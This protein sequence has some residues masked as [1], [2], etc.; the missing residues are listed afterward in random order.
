M[1]EEMAALTLLGESADWLKDAEGRS[2]RDH[3]MAA[4]ESFQAAWSGPTDNARQTAAHEAF[5]RLLVAL[6]HNHLYPSAL[7]LDVAGDKGARYLPALGTARRDFEHLQNFCVVNKFGIGEAHLLYLSL[8]LC[9]MLHRPDKTPYDNVL[10]NAVGDVIFLRVPLYRADNLGAFSS[11]L[12][13]RF[14]A[15]RIMRSMR[16]M[17]LMDES[18]VTDLTPQD[19]H[20]MRQML[21][22]PL[23][24]TAGHYAQRPYRLAFAVVDA[25]TALEEHARAHAASRASVDDRPPEE[26][27]TRLRHRI[28][29]LRER[30]DI[31]PNC[32]ARLSN[33]GI[34]ASIRALAHVD[35]TLGRDIYSFLRSEKYHAPV[36]HARMFELLPNNAERLRFLNF[37]FVHGK[38]NPVYYIDKFGK[39]IPGEKLRFESKETGFAFEPQPGKDGPGA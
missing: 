21:L 22:D 26:L 24:T 38:Q 7:V 9:R 27:F 39:Y 3:R 23:R 19:M 31:G 6:R 18:P 10:E 17:G 13:A 2:I 28:K 11:E 1:P 4:I 16:K 12:K 25:A 37:L 30:S 34:A 35:A 14:H 33:L 5:T 20:E 8:L 15:V 36:R 32:Q 29:Q